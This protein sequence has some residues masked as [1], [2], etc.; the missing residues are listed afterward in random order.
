M[1]QDRVDG[2]M[3]TLGILDAVLALGS[4]L[5]F[6]DSLDASNHFMEFLE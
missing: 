4:G 5:E 1:G 2:L 6:G 3:V